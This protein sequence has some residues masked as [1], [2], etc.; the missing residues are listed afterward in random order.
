MVIKKYDAE[1][2]LDCRNCPN[3]KNCTKNKKDC[4]EKKQ[5]ETFTEDYDRNQLGFKI[6]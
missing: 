6:L 3:N 5:L 2:F 1:V 4:L